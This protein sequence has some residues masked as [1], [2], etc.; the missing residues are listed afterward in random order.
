MSEPHSSYETVAQENEPHTKMVCILN[1][2][3]LFARIANIFKN[4]RIDGELTGADKSY[5][6]IHAIKLS[7]LCHSR[8]ENLEGFLKSCR[9]P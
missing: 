9:W 2:L 6:Q 7:V 4:R 3:E 8:D 1:E 5:Q